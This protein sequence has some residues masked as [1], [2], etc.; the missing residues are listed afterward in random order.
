MC[1]LLLGSFTNTL[2]PSFRVLWCNY[3]A[4]QGEVC[5]KEQA[6]IK[7]WEKQERWLDFPSEV[8]WSC[9]FAIWHQT[10]FFMVNC[11]IGDIIWLDQEYRPGHSEFVVLW[12]WVTLRNLLSVRPFLIFF[13]FF[14]ILHPWQFY[15]IGR[16]NWNRAVSN[17][18]QVDSCNSFCYRG[19]QY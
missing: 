14:C 1:S 11:F 6:E 16:C 9:G 17:S 8:V 18:G 4:H 19:F 3:S 12:P 5:I 13:F 10:G 2:V 7:R 15:A